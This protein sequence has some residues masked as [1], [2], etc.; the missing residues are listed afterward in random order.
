[1]KARCIDAGTMDFETAYRMQKDHVDMLKK[2][3]ARNLL[4]LLEHNPVFTIGRA[5]SGNNLLVE[6]SLLRT[7]GIDI[8]RTDRGGDITFHGPGQLIVYPIFDLKLLYKDMHKFLRDLEDVTIESLREFSIPSFRRTARTGVWTER[9]KIASIGV[10][11]S[12]WVTYHGLAINAN[13]DLG[14]F[15]MINPCGLTGVNM[16]SMQQELGH[17]VDLDRLKYIVREKFAD[18]FGLEIEY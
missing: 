5:G 17:Q 6:E 2:E 15:D 7:K 13:V 14:Y 10:G 9:A 1:M 18:I 4:I 16:T 8:I 12:N 3:R 11:A